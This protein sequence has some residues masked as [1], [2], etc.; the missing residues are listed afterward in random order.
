[1]KSCPLC[2]EPI[3]DEAI[4]C[5]HCGAFQV[6][7]ERGRDFKWVMAEAP[8]VSGMAVAS[9]ILGILWIYWIGSL[10]ALALGY[11]AKKEIERDPG[12]L[13]GRELATGGIVLGWV[14]VGTLILLIVFV[15]VVG[16][17]GSDWLE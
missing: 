10:L 14:G 12:K 17:V 9:L 2:A 6:S 15:G 13:A 3:Q 5:R 4:K 7:T 11:L 8:S 16:L 1:M